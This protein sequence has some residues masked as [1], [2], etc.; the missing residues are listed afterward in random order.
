MSVEDESYAKLS[1]GGLEEL[2][3]L[4]E[5]KVLGQNWDTVND[6]FIIYKL[7]LLAN[8][9]KD[10]KATKRNILKVVAKIYDPLGILSP[11]TVVMK[12]LSQQIC[13]GKFDWDSPLPDHIECRWKNWVNDLQKTRH[14]IVA[15]CIYDGI[16]EQIMSYSSMPLAV[17]VPRHIVR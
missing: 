7:D 16:T 14:I 2:S 15:R 17:L 6:T 11:L 9:T 5:R 12:I 4:N 8:F 3:A 10:L 13:L 1:V